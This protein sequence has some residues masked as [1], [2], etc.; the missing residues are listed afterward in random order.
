MKI[1]KGARVL[2]KLIL[3]HGRDGVGKTTLASEFSNPIFIGPESGTYNLNVERFEGVESWDDITGAL[4]QVYKMKNKTV[5]VDSL[6]WCEILIMK[7]LCEAQGC[8]S[9]EQCSGGFGKGY[10][11]VKN[12]FIKMQT[13]LNALRSKG[14]DIVCICHSNVAE[15]N[16]PAT[17]RPYNRYELK[18]FK[19]KSGN[20]DLRAL[21]REYVDAVIFLQHEVIVTGDVKKPAQTR[22]NSTD[23]ILMHLKPDARWDAKN[24]FGIREDLTFNLGSGY[25][26]LNKVLTKG[27]NNG[28]KKS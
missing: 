17:D 5:V 11:D 7:H 6:D 27:V 2:P 28:T 1:T 13:N 12:E 26:T 15:F 9:I 25:Q 21:W 18:L 22:G 19:S 10:T 20:V 14:H 16:D 23:R 24:R 8:D 3:I 4:R